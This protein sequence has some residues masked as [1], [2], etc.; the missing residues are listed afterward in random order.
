MLDY[1][2]RLKFFVVLSPSKLNQLLNKLQNVLNFRW[3]GHH[4]TKE[5][6]IG[7][8]NDLGFVL[9]SQKVYFYLDLEVAAKALLK[10]VDGE[11]GLEFFFVFALVVCDQR[12]KVDNNRTDKLV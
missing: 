9:V 12:S 7:A 5:V 1:V 8:L 6:Y 11:P 10:V 4:L 3:L 2:H